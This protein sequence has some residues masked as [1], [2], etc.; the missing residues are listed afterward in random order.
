MPVRKIPKEVCTRWNSLYEMLLVGHQYQKPLQYVFN[1]HHYHPHEQIQDS[2]WNE[3][4][5]L[6]IFLEK[7][8][9][10]TKAFSGQYYPTIAQVLFYICGLTKLFAEYRESN[11]AIDDMI[12]KFKKYF[13]SYSQYL[14][15][16]LY[17]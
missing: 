1:A 6:C 15:D 4:E 16:C 14:F 17:T 7:F 9:I 5:G 3:I 13:F 10:A 11:E 8:Y 2:D 12:F